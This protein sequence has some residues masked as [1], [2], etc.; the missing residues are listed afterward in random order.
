MNKNVRNLII[1]GVVLLIP[2]IILVYRNSKTEEDAPAT[3]VVPTIAPAEASSAASPHGDTTAAAPEIL[4]AD[5]A[6]DQFTVTDSGLMLYDLEEGSGESPQDGDIISVNYTMWLADG[7]AFIDSSDGRPIEFILGAEQVFPGWN[8][9]MAGMKPGGIRQMRLSPELGLGDTGGGPIPPN[10]SLILEVELVEFR[11]P[12]AP[13]EV[14]ESEFTATESGLKIADLT[15][16]SGDAPAAGDMVTVEY[17]IWLADG[18]RFVASSVDLGVPFDFVMGSSQ[19][20][21][22]WNEGMETMAVGG[23]RQ[24]IIP[25]DLALGEAGVPGLIPPNATLIMEVE[26]LAAAPQAKPTAVEE[27]DYTTTDSGLKYIDLVEGDGESPEA[28]QTVVVHYTGWLEDGSIFDSSVD[29]GQPF[30][31]VLGQGMVIPGWDEGVADMRVGG[32]RQLVIPP[33]LAYGDSGG[34]PIP[35]GSTLIFEV[36]LLEIR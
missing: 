12:P 8:E 10:A 5:I 15:V 13:S 14:A 24:L 19:I 36:E 35:P 2:L 17:G 9:G 33:E 11:A 34:G 26:L 21:P 20:F 4:P 31:F 25:P 28:G 30:D 18:R 32:K 29:R 27:S 1:L 22:G 16:G 6:A 23:R 3:A 7:R